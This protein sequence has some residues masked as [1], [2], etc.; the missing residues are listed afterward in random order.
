MR[1]LH[2]TSPLEHGDDVLTIQKVLRDQGF[3]PG[4]LDGKY[5][6]SSFEAVRDF[7]STHHL[8]VDGVVGDVT[9]TELM[10]LKNKPPVVTTARPNSRIGLAMLAEAQKHI[11]DTETPRD[12]NHT[13]YGRWFGVDGVPWCNIFVSYCA[14][15]GANY[16]ICSGFRG[17]GVYKKGCTY[18]P[19][20]EAWMRATGMWMGRVTPQPGYVAIFNWDGGVP[21]HI[22]IVEKDLGGGM[23]QT[24]EGNTAVGNDSN[25]GE[26]MRRQRYLT[27]VD[28]FGRLAA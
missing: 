1:E 20:T 10:K 7:Q 13:V 23:F 26:V 14:S 5:G 9:R 22:G 21:D 11:G 3:S 2:I 12:S 4:P 18:V 27:Q 19:T 17:P 28:G 25:G 6:S 8:P 24:I 15:V 16:T